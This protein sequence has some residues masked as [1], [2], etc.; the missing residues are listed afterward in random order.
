M[1]RSL[2]ALTAPA[3]VAAVLF[4]ASLGRA[5]RLAG[6]ELPSSD[7]AVGWP[8]E[9]VRLSVDEA[10]LPRGLSLETILSEA[11][12]AAHEWRAP[13]S[14]LEVSVSSTRG[15]RAEPEVSG[16][17]FVGVESEVDGCFCLCFV[18]RPIHGGARAGVSMRRC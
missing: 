14:T 15:L 16:P 2:T 12:A 1:M 6:E 13:C 10:A 17:R 18:S 7:P 8:S 3:L 4:P 11:Q 5:Y 9:Q